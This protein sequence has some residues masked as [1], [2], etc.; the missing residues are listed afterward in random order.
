MPFQTET[1]AFQQNANRLDRPAQTGLTVPGSAGSLDNGHTPSISGA[2]TPTGSGATLASAGAQIPR[3]NVEK[4]AYFI[5]HATSSGLISPAV[6]GNAKRD[7][8]IKDGT[9]LVLLTTFCKS[10][11]APSSAGGTGETLEQL[12][13]TL[14][15]GG[16]S[17][18]LEFFPLQRRSF[19]E[20]QRD[21]KERGLERLAAWYGKVADNIR[22]DEVLE[23][24]KEILNSHEDETAAAIEELTAFVDSVQKSTTP[25]N[26]QD[27]VVL[28]WQS[29]MSRDLDIN[30][31]N[32]DQVADRVMKWIK[33]RMMPLCH[34]YRLTQLL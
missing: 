18:L 21:F 32:K 27:V 6:I 28:L 33:V 20:L 11:L 1:P 14:R 5:A 12:T 2:A 8:L 24:C 29:I 7:H 17:D 30:S 3:P 34:S 10:Y 9:S 25:V 26:E 13:T 4:L 19:A 16:C 22:R 31:T 15:K 23:R